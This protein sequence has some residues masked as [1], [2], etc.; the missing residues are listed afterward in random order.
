M[1]HASARFRDWAG[2]RPWMSGG[3]FAIMRSGG[4]TASQMLSDS[5][6]SAVFAADAG[7][8]EPRLWAM[9]AATLEQSILFAVAE[10]LG[11]GLSDRPRELAARL[12]PALQFRNM[13]LVGQMSC[14]L[15]SCRVAETGELLD[16]LSK[17][18]QPAPL[19]IVLFVHGENAAGAP[20]VFD[21][22]TGAP[23]ELA[24]AYLDAPESTRWAA[25][26]HHRLAWES[27]GDLERTFTF[28][29]A[30]ELASLPARAG[31]DAAL[32]RA[33]GTLA[34]RGFAALDGPTRAAWRA[35]AA[36]SDT[37]PTAGEG[38][39][40]PE[41]GDDLR[42]APWLARALLRLGAKGAPRWRLR[43]C[44]ACRPLATEVL[45]RC[46]ELE[47]R[48]HAAHATELIFAVTSAE[49]RAQELYS[50]FKAGESPLLAYPLDHPA[51]PNQPEDV[52]LFA[53]MGEVVRQLRPK[54]N[55]SVAD[56]YWELVSLRNGVA[57]GHH[58]G[59]AQWQ[60]LRRLSGLSI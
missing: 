55:C 21:F 58:V 10:A 27:A 4:P 29:S 30:P 53:T 44:L 35:Y 24:L 49:A 45:G 14:E 59:W 50:R 3:G 1:F 16:C 23:N 8:S 9:E 57:H 51:P 37:L 15:D 43:G 38:L 33:L 48:L 40:R 13:I 22:R 28:A 54:L 60:A 19:T 41:F 11:F 25:Y 39:W 31:D 36:G 34:D 32:E 2:A 46:L 20:T 47:T 56:R 17:L 42:P 18:P 7:V 5:L 26:L 52:W 12:G 6:A